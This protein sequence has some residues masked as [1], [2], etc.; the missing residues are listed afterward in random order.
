MTQ[1]TSVSPMKALF[2]ILLLPLTLSAFAAEAPSAPARAE[3]LTHLH[4]ARQ[5]TD[6]KLVAQFKLLYARTALSYSKYEMDLQGKLVA[7]QAGAA[8][9]YSK[10]VQKW[11]ENRFNVTALETQAEKQATREKFYEA[12]ATAALSGREDVAELA[13]LALQE[14]QH[15][16]KLNQQLAKDGVDFAKE[17]H[18]RFEGAERLFRKGAMSQQEFVY[19][20]HA[21]SFAKSLLAASDQGVKLY[22]AMVAEAQK[23]LADTTAKP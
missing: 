11:I 6:E 15:L 2:S 22:E 3:R 13:R 23:E 10:A 14:R 7:R 1:R 17:V 20:Q 16:L 9:D 19:H 8:F 18:F 12:R 4:E 21:E 5:A